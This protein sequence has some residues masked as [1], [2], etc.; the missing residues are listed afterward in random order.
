MPLEVALHAP[1]LLRAHVPYAH[2]QS[3]FR[4]ELTSRTLARIDA[5]RLR[6]KRLLL[7]EYDDG[8]LDDAV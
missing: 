4:D 5:L 6:Y 1:D 7:R 2:G 8:Y 3:G